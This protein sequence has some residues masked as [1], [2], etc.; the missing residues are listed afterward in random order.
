MGKSQKIFSRKEKKYLLTYEQYERLI[1]K[2]ERYMEQDKYG[3]HTICSL[4]YDTNDYELIRTSIEKPLY[5]EK[6]RV[7][8]YGVATAGTAVFIEIKKKFQGIVG[9]RRI[10]LPYFI[11]QN[12]LQEQ[13]FPEI[14]DEHIHI[15]KEL[16]WF[17][18]RYKIEPKTLIA[19]ERRAYFG[20]EDKKFRV[21]FDFNIRSREVDLALSLGDYGASIT[22]EFYCLM[23]IKALG[24]FPMWLVHI[25]SEEAI[26]P[27]TFSKYA[28][29]YQRKILPN[30]DYTHNLSKKITHTQ[31]GT[32]YVF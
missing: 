27:G 25:L 10:E 31:G 5:K 24:S 30:I 2:L 4:Y 14:D 32:F 1:P 28:Q 7:R 21:T 17:L 18:N 6:F 19:Y 20:K 26:Y 22:D 12:H 8:S 13:Y 3:L 16:N 11:A 23:E 15:R 9:K 29:C